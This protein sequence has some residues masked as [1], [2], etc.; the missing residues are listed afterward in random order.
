[1]SLSKDSI[2]IIGVL[3]AEDKRRPAAHL[4]PENIVI[5]EYPNKKRPIFHS[6]G[7]FQPVDADED[8]LT[9]NTKSCTDQI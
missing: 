1:M 8:H 3:K 2:P 5:F 7:W 4:A 9:T 6:L